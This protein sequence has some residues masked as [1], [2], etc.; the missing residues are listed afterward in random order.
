MQTDAKEE[1]YYDKPTAKPADESLQNIEP[2]D[3]RPELDPE[4]LNQPEAAEE[5]PTEVRKVETPSTTEQDES[6]LKKPIVTPE[7]TDAD[8]SESEKAPEQD[9]NAG[10]P[11]P[12]GEEAQETGDTPKLINPLDKT[13]R[14]AIPAIG[15]H[16]V[17]PA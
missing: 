14:R 13:A 9:P 6:V 4:A 17:V 1:E 16:Y 5:R 11:D 7:A 8:S 3:T 12:D 2:A 15:P 10:I